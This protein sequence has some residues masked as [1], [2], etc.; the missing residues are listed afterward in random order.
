MWEYVEVQNM[1]LS[2]QG[3]VTCKMT[4]QAVKRRKSSCDVV[5]VQLCSII[6]WTTLDVLHKLLDTPLPISIFQRLVLTN[7]ELQTEEEV[8]A[9]EL[10]SPSS[11]KSRRMR[12]GSRRRTP[13]MIYWM[14]S[15][16]KSL[17]DDSG[18]PWRTALCQYAWVAAQFYC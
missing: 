10:N 7:K 11:K 5:V 12:L 6:Y 2:N 8:R 14:L 17:R 4:H 1:W 16:W 9:S 18:K 15:C 3:E 13:S